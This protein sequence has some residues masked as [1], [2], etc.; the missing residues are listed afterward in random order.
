MADDQFVLVMRVTFMPFPR[1]FALNSFRSSPGTV[2]RDNM[3]IA[4][5][6]TD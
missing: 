3:R 4:G 6:Q 5:V 1:S 2:I